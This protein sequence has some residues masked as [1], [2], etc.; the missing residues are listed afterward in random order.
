[1]V[2]RSSGTP[3][4]TWTWPTWVVSRRRVLEAV[5]VLLESPSPSRRIFIGSHSLPPSLIRRIGPSVV[6]C[7]LR[8]LD[9]LRRAWNRHISFRLDR[10]DVG[11]QPV[12]LML[13]Y[14]NGLYFGAHYQSSLWAQRND[15]FKWSVASCGN[16]R[17]LMIVTNMCYQ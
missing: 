9:V 5:F 13:S 14:Y 3:V 6:W 16:S 7:P 1:L 12:S 15:H 17:C 11:T 4:A 8:I 2:P 10:G